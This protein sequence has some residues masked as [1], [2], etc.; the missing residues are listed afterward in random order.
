MK[1]TKKYDSTQAKI[2]IFMENLK[3]QYW[4]KESFFFF[5]FC[6]FLLIY[7]NLRL[8]TL[9]P[10]FLPYIDINQPQVYMN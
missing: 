3:V 6:S 7:F 9:P 4:A 1:K 5:F 2:Y 8:I 10:W